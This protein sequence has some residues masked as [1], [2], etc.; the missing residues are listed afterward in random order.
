MHLVFVIR[1]GEKVTASSF[2]YLGY[3]V[4]ILTGGKERLTMSLNFC[5]N[6]N[7]STQCTKS[8]VDT[9]WHSTKHLILCR[10]VLFL[11]MYSSAFVGSSGCSGKNRL[12]TTA[13][14][15]YP[16]LSNKEGPV[17]LEIC[18]AESAVRSLDRFMFAC[19]HEG[20]DENT[21]DSTRKPDGAF[22]MHPNSPQRMI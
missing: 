22:A 16:V 21:L 18:F 4:G 10:Q 17:T 3:F 1:P 19:N 5:P 15:V 12:K 8:S 20:S 2:P 7:T 9:A 6:H 14:V 13:I 11:S